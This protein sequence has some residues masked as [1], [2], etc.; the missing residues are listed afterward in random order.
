[1]QMWAAWSGSS[2]TCQSKRKTSFTGCIDSSETGY[3]I[4]PTLSSTVLFLGMILNH[5]RFLSLLLSYRI[6]PL[7]NCMK[8]NQRMPVKTKTKKAKTKIGLKAFNDLNFRNHLVLFSIEL[9]QLSTLLLLHS[10][11]LNFEHVRL[12]SVRLIKCRLNV[13]RWALIA[14]R[15]PGRTP[16]AIERFWKMAYDP[17]FAERRLKRRKR[18]SSNH[19]DGDARQKNGPRC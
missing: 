1:M 19:G 8:K 12:L 5:P 4:S 3:K 15:I 9:Q 6:C 13:C 10:G 14:G 18:T 11:R 2:S 17:S 16:E 7:E